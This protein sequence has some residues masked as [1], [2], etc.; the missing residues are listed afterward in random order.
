MRL[1]ND[2]Q[3][4]MKDTPAWICIVCGMPHYHPHLWKKPPKTIDQ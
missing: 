2:P 4:K 3:T 1:E